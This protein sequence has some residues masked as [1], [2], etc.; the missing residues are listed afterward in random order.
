MN[1]LRDPVALRVNAELL[2]VA[3]AGPQGFTGRAG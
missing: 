2:T 3:F 1:V